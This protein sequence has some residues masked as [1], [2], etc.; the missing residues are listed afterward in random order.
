MIVKCI[1]Y[2]LYGSVFNSVF[3]MLFYYIMIQCYLSNFRALGHAAN[4]GKVYILHP[5]L[6]KVQIY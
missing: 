6:F 4:R 2:L 1:I 5:Q 3:D